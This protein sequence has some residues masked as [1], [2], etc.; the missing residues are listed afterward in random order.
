GTVT[1]TTMLWNGPLEAMN[2]P[3]KEQDGT[4]SIP[5]TLDAWELLDAPGCGDWQLSVEDHG[6]GQTGTLHG[7]TLNRRLALFSFAHDAAYYERLI[8][9][10]SNQ[11][12]NVRDYFLEVSRGKFAF[13]NAG[14]YERNIPR[15]PSY[16]VPNDEERVVSM[17][18]ELEDA[19]FNFAQYDR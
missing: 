14:I 5:A 15:A 16:H 1:K 18:H 10:A 13:V 17:V 11:F 9:G 8:F 3:D 4:L 2:H 19:G 6:Q 12:P 7:W